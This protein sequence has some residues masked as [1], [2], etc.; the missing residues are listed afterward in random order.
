M[1][2][3]KSYASRCL[4]RAKLDDRTRKRWVRHG[5][6]RWLWDRADISGAIRY[7]IEGQ[8]EAMA[9]FEA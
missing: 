3:L 6:T 5:S 9:V 2:D 7:G 1:N 8:G 4:N